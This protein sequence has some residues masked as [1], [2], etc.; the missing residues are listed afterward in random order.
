MKKFRIKANV[1]IVGAY[2]Y[3]TPAI[4]FPK[5]ANLRLQMGNS[6]NFESFHNE[7]KY[8]SKLKWNNLIGENQGIKKIRKYP[9]PSRARKEISCRLS[10]FLLKVAC[11][12]FI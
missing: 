7:Q 10:C 12:G 8:R 9:S 3:H 4:N 5:S 11:T 6:E 1:N 2:F